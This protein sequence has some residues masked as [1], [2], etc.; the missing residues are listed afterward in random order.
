MHGSNRFPERNEKKNAL[1]SSENKCMEWDRIALE[2]ILE[3]KNSKRMPKASKMIRKKGKTGKKK[4]LKQTNRQT[5]NQNIFIIHLISHLIILVFTWEIKWASLWPL[6]TRGARV[7][8]CVIK[9][10]PHIRMTFVRPIDR[11]ER[12]H[13]PFLFVSFWDLCVMCEEFLCLR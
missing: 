1:R 8:L 7:C 5:K 10:L 13:Y 12:W 4:V 2:A 11:Y 9:W 6:C 3:L